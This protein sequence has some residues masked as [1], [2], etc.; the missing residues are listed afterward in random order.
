MVLAISQQLN[1][2]NHTF[3]YEIFS[4][5]STRNQIE[6][7]ASIGFTRW[8]THQAIIRQSP[9]QVTPVDQSSSSRARDCNRR[10]SLSLSQLALLFLTA[11]STLSSQ[12]KHKAILKETLKYL[13]SETGNDRTT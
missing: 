9:G 13:P 6:F 1:H 12:A 11:R 10:S 8:F 7:I 2:I 5:R 3:E 4:P